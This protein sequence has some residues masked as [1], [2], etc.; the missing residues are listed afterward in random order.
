MYGYATRSYA[1]SSGRFGRYGGIAIAVGLHLIVIAVLLSMAP[2]RN[3][4]TSAAPI[5]VKL[6]T[7]PA[8]VEVKPEVLPRPVPVKPRVQ[9]V[10]PVVTPPVT[11][12][13]TEAPTPFVAPP[14]PPV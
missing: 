14:A 6:V 2:V 9:K 8:R 13:V 5:F 11:T 1:E 10:K 7:P 12:A 4:L 3:A